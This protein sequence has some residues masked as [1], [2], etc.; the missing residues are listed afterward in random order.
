MRVET[1]EVVVYLLELSAE[2]CRTLV[3]V[4]DQARNTVNDDQDLLRKNIMEAI[5]LKMRAKGDWR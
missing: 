2:E 5:E 4:L 3:S 1:E